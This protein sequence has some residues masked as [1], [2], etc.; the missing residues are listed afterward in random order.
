MRGGAHHFAATRTTGRSNAQAVIS[1]L[2]P[3]GASNFLAYR[4]GE[5]GALAAIHGLN[6]HTVRTSGSLDASDII[7]AERA[8]RRH[9]RGIVPA[10]DRANARFEA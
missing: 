3:T 8:G 5:A 6:N 2:H 4:A 9:T 1:A 7:S 10:H